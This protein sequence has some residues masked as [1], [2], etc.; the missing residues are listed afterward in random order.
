MGEKSEYPF[1]QILASGGSLW[2]RKPNSPG[3][4][5]VIPC[6]TPF[7]IKLDGPNS[8]R[9]V[10][11]VCD[12]GKY[13]V[14]Q[15]RWTGTQFETANEAVNTVREI[16]TNAFLYMQFKFDGDWIDADRLRK[17]A[18]RTLPARVEPILDMLLSSTKGQFGEKGR[19]YVGYNDGKHVK[20]V[21]DMLLQNP[22]ILDIYKN[23]VDA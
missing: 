2:K 5:I 22:E 1:L 7:R 11:G 18:A 16:S 14:Q 23:L 13:I 6:G 19:T 8:N 3:G 12:G 20:S 21:V 17:N 4:T 9:F 15:G 10:T